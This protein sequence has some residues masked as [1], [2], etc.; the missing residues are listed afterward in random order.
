MHPFFENLVECMTEDLFLQEFSRKY[1]YEESQMTLLKEV[2]FAMQ[3][4]ILNDNHTDKAGW[5]ANCP[6]QMK[7]SKAEAEICSV[8]MTLGPGVDALQEEYLAGANA[9]INNEKALH[10][11]EAE[12]NDHIYFI[13]A[14]NEIVFL[15]QDGYI[16]T[17][18][19]C[20]GKDYYDRQ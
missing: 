7:D 12:D 17:Y 5:K 20:S 16:R 15:S 18:F 10:K 4:C 6:E 14:T 8:C 11:L 9:V 3:K 1:H 19:M 13:E 2:S